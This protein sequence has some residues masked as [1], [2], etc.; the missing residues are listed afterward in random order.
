MDLE[1]RSLQPSLKATLLAKLREYKS[2]LNKLKKEVNKLALTGAKQAAHDLESGMMDPHAVCIL[3]LSFSPFLFFSFFHLR[4]PLW[5]MLSYN[6]TWIMYK[7]FHRKVVWWRLTMWQLSQGY[8]NFILNDMLASVVRKFLRD[9][10]SMVLHIVFMLGCW[11]Q[12]WS[13]QSEIRIC[14]T[15]KSVT[16]LKG[17]DQFIYMVICDLSIGFFSILLVAS[18]GKPW[19]KLLKMPGC[20]AQKRFSIYY[21]L[22]TS[23]PSLSFLHEIAE[24]IDVQHV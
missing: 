1:A 3:K 16:Y 17:T 19:H 12:S 24:S 6:L 21:L 11:Y 20:Q 14:M 18:V 10:L 7:H 5:Y 13:N 23:V 2:D 22:T 4:I 8:M 15:C 9:R